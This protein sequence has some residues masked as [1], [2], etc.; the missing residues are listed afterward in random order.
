MRDGYAEKS[1]T[2]A[3]GLRNAFEC[4]PACTGSLPGSSGLEARMSRKSFRR[5]S[6]D[7]RRRA[8]LEAT[9]DCI[10]EGGLSAASARRIAQRAGVTAGLIR[11]YFGSKDEMVLQAYAYFMGQLTEQASDVAGTS[12]GTAN[13][14]LAWF[15]AANLRRPNLSAR[16]V[17]LWASFI[18]RAERSADYAAIHR[19]SY[20]EFLEILEAMIHPVLTA[21]G[22]PAD[23]ETCRSHAIALNG[24]IDGL[25]L[26][27]SLDHGLHN[28]DRVP[29][30]ALTAAE[31]IMRL[32]QGTLSRLLPDPAAEETTQTTVPKEPVC[33]TQ[34]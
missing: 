20:R 31:G 30:I 3:H 28:P 33:D 5:L 14:A 24:L 7:D 22:R 16:K 19:D 8:L 27:A 13:H 9:L 15:V 34:P 26:E 29:W 21:H 17:S 12:G 11:H 4:E 6:Q 10:A 25:W 1:G 23:R 18:G 2:A 32:P